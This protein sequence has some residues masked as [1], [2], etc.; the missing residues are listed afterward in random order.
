MLRW[1]V[2]SGTGCD[3]ITQKTGATRRL[4]PVATVIALPPS[5]SAAL[6]P[7]FFMAVGGGAQD[8]HTRRRFLASR[9]GGAHRSVPGEPIKSLDA[10]RGGIPIGRF[11]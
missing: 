7:R 11:L 9:D 10:S 2:N 3:G 4:L 6:P 5:P 8:P 1:P